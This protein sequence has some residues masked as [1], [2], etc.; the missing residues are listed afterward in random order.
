MVTRCPSAV[1]TLKIR[2]PSGSRH[3]RGAPAA[4]GPSM[5]CS[6]SALL[7]TRSPVCGS[8][9]EETEISPI[10]Y[11]IVRPSSVSAPSSI[12]SSASV[13]RCPS[14]PLAPATPASCSSGPAGGPAGRSAGGGTHA[15]PKTAPSG[16]VTRQWPGSPA[17]M[18]SALARSH[19][20][21]SP[22]PYSISQASVMR[23]RAS[24]DARRMPALPSLSSC[25]RISAAVG[26]RRARVPSGWCTSRRP[27]SN[28]RTSTPNGD[29]VRESSQ[30][31]A[32]PG[33]KSDLS[34]RP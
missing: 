20:S 32:P 28:S 11:S 33:S 7:V 21:R 5:M 30:S 15:R 16:L 34:R 4:S 17:N 22:R 13:L 29:T 23:S 26:F 25:A 19:T 2:V 24:R 18:A 31:R 14:T 27:E 10:S 9:S 12:S 6:P 1:G 3:V 8:T